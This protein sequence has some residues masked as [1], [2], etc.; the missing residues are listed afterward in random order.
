MLGEQKV[1]AAI[2]GAT[3]VAD[4]TLSFGLAP[5]YGAM[6]VAAANAASLTLM[7]CLFYLLARR[8]LG[9]DISAFAR[10]KKAQP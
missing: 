4:L 1:C 7:A 2:S 10:T 9:F 8:R 3:A 6:G 5:T